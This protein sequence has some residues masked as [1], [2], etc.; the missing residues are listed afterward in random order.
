MPKLKNVKHKHKQFIR[1]AE[2]P[3]KRRLIRKDIE[4]LKDVADYRFL[5]SHQIR[6]LHPGGKSY[7]Q[8]RL[9]WMFHAKLLDRPGAQ[10]PAFGFR[11]RRHHIYALGNKGADV[12]FQEHPELRGRINWQQKN[13]ELKDKYL[14]HTIMVTDFRVC[15]TLALKNHKRAALVSWKQGKDVKDYV[16]LN[17]GA[18]ATVEP[19]GLFTLKDQGDLIHFCLEADRSTMDHQKFLR[20]LKA[21]WKWWKEGGPSK[22]FNIKRFRVLTVTKSEERAEQLR[23]LARQ[24]DEKQQ[25]SEMFWFACEKQYHFTKPTTILEPVWRT[26]KNDM[27]HHL[28][29]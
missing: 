1:S 18:R 13:R 24:V 22:K 27:H 20:K 25:G 2:L 14:W 4:L 21:Y 29:E 16:R 6:L 26:P 7:R 12:L 15:L 28:L 10:T 3:E 5:D 8:R 9:Q 23:Q 11:P 17:G 19:D